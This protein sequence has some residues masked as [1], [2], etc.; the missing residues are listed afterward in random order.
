MFPIKIKKDVYVIIRIS[1]FASA[2]TI[3]FLSATVLVVAGPLPLSTFVSA[4]APTS[5]PI[6]NPSS[7]PRPLVSLAPKMFQLG[8]EADVGFTRLGADA[9]LQFKNMTNARVFDTVPN[10]PY[11]QNVYLTD[12]LKV[13]ALGGE[14]DL[15]F[16]HDAE[17]LH[18]YDQ[19]TAGFDV[20]QAYLA[21]TAHNVTL[22][23]GKFFTLAGAEYVR[24]AL[25]DEYSR[26][27]LFGYA[28]PFTHT[29]VRLTYAPNAKVSYIA[30]ENLG[31]DQFKKTSGDDT[32]EGGILFTPSPEV[33]FSV[34]TYN[35]DEYDTLLPFVSSAVGRRILYDSVLTIKASETF[36]ITGNYDNASQT[37][38]PL[39]D[40]AGRQALARGVARW[41]GFAAY[42]HYAIT[43]KW[44]AT[45]RGETFYDH[46]G[47]RTGIDQRWREGTLAAQYEPSSRMILRAEYRHDF[48][49]QFIFAQAN[50]SELS[51]LG[52]LGL[53]AIVKL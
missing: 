22:Q 42:L 35:G 32:L 11:V 12:A 46:G 7:V 6:P 45:L 14:V 25:N 17:V 1:A 19:K 27:I 50:G 29:G 31:W 20:T 10:V 21:Y 2:L 8:G 26:S 41:G 33:T 30:G 48:S 13:G 36:T 4:P 39:F 15:S 5:T 44:I 43:P 3:F 34:Q 51:S 38:A 52:T 28:I 9:A 53:E 18:S 23:A 49:N 40:A 47:Y 16:G 24:S 37:N